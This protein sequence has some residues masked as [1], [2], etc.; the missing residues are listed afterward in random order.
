LPNTR[1]EW[2]T[3]SWPIRIEEQLGLF[4]QVAA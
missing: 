3:A 2:V 1:R 4:G